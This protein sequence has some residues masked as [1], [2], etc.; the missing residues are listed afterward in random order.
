MRETS[1]NF[2]VA[3][4]AQVLDVEE[5]LSSNLANELPAI[6]DGISAVQAS[7]EFRC[8]GLKK[9]IEECCARIEQ[10][11]AVMQKADMD[12]AAACEDH[13]CYGWLFRTCP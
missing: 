8:G 4:L 13:P 1:W 5:R 12:L 10:S 9:E 2:G 6:A 3:G 7:L 11:K